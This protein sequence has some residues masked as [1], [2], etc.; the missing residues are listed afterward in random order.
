MREISAAIDETRA[1]SGLWSKLKRTGLSVKAGITFAK[2]YL[3][4]VSKQGLPETIR[5]QPAW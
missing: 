2:L 3:Q 4:P 5:L 1:Q